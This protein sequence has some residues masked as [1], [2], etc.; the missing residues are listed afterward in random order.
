VLEERSGSISHVV[1]VGMAN[2]RIVSNCCTV[3]RRSGV[4]ENPAEVSA[5]NDLLRLK[6]YKSGS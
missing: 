3:C 6:L 4:E 1:C 2:P 5:Q